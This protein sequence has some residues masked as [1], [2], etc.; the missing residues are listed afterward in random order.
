MTVTVSHALEK[1][2]S[3]GLLL[4]LQSGGLF[5]LNES[6][7]FIWD[8][9]LAGTPV[10]ELAGELADRHGLSAAMAND[11]VAKALRIEP[12][13]AASLT[14]PGE[15][16]YRRSAKGYVFSRNGTPLLTVDE[17]GSSIELGRI[18]MARS[19]I[20]P[21]LQGISPKLMALRGHFVVHASAVVLNGAIVAFCGESG[22]GKT[23]T[24]RALVRAGATPFCEDKLVLQDVN[25]VA[26][27]LGGSEERIQVWTE[28]AAN[29]LASGSAASCVELDGA[30][31]DRCVPLG[32]MGFIDVSR[33]AGE[34][35]DPV[36][37]TSL[38]VA[39]AI[40]R[41]SFYGSDAPEDW[42]RRL[43]NAASVARRIHA[44]D[45]EMPRGIP[46]LEQA[47]ADFVRRGALAALPLRS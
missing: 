25:G 12:R 40:F 31:G 15:F 38:E 4:D 34:S 41:N 33:R 24:A 37:L 2:P 27:G 19:D 22:A 18:D 21:I 6:A 42:I 44:Y 43:R 39:S 45:L 16:L 28:A 13:D 9:W 36:P 20:L 26:A 8:G 23:T 35:I 7:T 17:S 3:G 46:T 14:P 30:P 32:E 5:Q 10:A 1:F 29:K 11:D 47:A